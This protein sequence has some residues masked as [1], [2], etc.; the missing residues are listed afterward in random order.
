MKITKKLVMLLSIVLCIGISSCSKDDDDSG[1]GGN[2]SVIDVKVENGNEYNDWIATVKALIATDENS[3]GEWIGYEVASCEYKN[4]GLKLNLP[5]SV[6][7]QYLDFEVWDDDDYA[8]YA[9]F[10]VSD[11]NAKLAAIWILA[12]N[13]QDREIGWFELRGSNAN[14]EVGAWYMY[15]DRNFTVKGTDEY[16]GEKTTYDMS[17][18]KGWNIWYEIEKE[19]KDSY[20]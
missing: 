9:D 10:Q 14:T 2:P 5:S 11:K 7:S 17:F 13:E 4:G 15:A 12:Y 19:E 20:A 16:E 8:D 1:G 3:R 18:R 6:P